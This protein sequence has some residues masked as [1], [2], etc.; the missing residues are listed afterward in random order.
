MLQGGNDN[1]VENN[2]FVDG[3][4]SQVYVSNFAENSTGLVFRRNIVAYTNPAAVLFAT[5]R[6]DEHVIRI[7]GNLYFHAGG[8]EP[9]IRGVVPWADWQKR[10][11][12]RNS[13]I[14]D[15]LFLDPAHDNYTLRPDSPAFKLG[16]ELRPG[17]VEHAKLSRKRHIQEPRQVDRTWEGDAQ[18]LDTGQIRGPD[19]RLPIVVGQVSHLQRS[20]R[21]QLWLIGE[22]HAASPDV[23]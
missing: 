10:G 4:Q 7:D 13:V 1:R 17:Q 20:H 22:S 5:S 16:F 12:D 18:S 9:V 15:P 8:K 6:L 19:D 21:R 14:A 23:V 11:F 2:I 3:A